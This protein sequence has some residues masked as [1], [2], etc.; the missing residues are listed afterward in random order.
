MSLK[1]PIS[2]KLTHPLL[3]KKSFKSA[4]EKKTLE[5]AS[6]VRRPASSYAQSLT[7]IPGSSI[8]LSKLEVGISL[9]RGRTIPNSSSNQNVRRVRRPKLARIASIMHESDASIP[10]FRI[11]SPNLTVMTLFPVPPPAPPPVSFSLSP[12]SLSFSSSLQEPWLPFPGRA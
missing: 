5:Y 10:I 6:P 2:R 11:S 12:L 3:D 9:L 8:K 7:G 4:S 1:L